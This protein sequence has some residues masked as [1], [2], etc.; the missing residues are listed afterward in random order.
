M[1]YFT[2]TRSQTQPMQ[3]LHDSADSDVV[4]LQQNFNFYL[5]NM[6]DTLRALKVLEFAQHGLVA[7]LEMN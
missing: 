7:L 4:W 3:F 6:F 5:E 2:D 1:S